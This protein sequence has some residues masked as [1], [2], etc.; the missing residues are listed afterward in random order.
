M[1]PRRPPARH[2]V[3]GVKLGRGRRADDRRLVVGAKVSRGAEEGSIDVLLAVE[4]VD[5]VSALPVQLSR[6][7]QLRHRRGQCVAIFRQFVGDL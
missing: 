1:D 2:V 5:E 3:D 4:Q 7:A 6:P